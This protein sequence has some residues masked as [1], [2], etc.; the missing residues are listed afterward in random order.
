MSINDIVFRP[1]YSCLTPMLDCD[2]LVRLNV[3]TLQTSATCATRHGKD[4]KSRDSLKAPTRY[5]Y[6]GASP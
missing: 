2:D 3:S 4:Y 1:A 6:V 5:I